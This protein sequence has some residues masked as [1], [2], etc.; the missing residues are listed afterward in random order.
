LLLTELEK[1]VAQR[2]TLNA[3]RMGRGNIP[4]EEDK[5]KGGDLVFLWIPAKLRKTGESKRIYCYVVTL[6]RGGYQLNSYFGLISGRYPHSELNAADG[7]PGDGTIPRIEKLTPEE[8]AKAKKVT[9]AKA[10]SFMNDRQAVSTTQR[11]GQ[12]RKRGAIIP[13][14]RHI[15]G[16][17]AP[18][19]FAERIQTRA[20]E[21]IVSLRTR[22]SG[23]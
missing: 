9:L 6:T 23:N 22:R 1:R 4:S 15:R 7:Q 11:A 14:A 8:A 2:N 3:E 21:R 5:Y 19:R 12:K 18:I 13:Q 16:Q 20:T 10:V 17:I